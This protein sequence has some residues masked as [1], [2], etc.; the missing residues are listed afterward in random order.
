MKKY[1]NHQLGMRKSSEIEKKLWRAVT[2]L[3]LIGKKQK[4]EY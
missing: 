4:K 3:F 1:S 2:P